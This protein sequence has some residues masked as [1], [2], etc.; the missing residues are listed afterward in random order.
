MNNGT[1]RSSAVADEI[2][3]RRDIIDPPRTAKV[4]V[5][6]KIKP[7]HL[8]RG[9][10]LYIRQSSLHQLRENQEST[11]RQYQLRERLLA[12]GW[13]RDQVVIIDEDLGVSGSGNADRD[14][15]RRLLKLVTDQ[16]LGIVL[17]LEMSRLARN[18]K[19]WHDLFEVCAVFDSL[20]ADE[21][22][23]FCPNDSNDRMVL[24]LKG[25]ISEMELHAMKVRLERGRMNK[26]ERGELFQDLPVGFVPDEGGLPEL[27]PDESARH[28]MQ[29]F[30]RLFESLGSGSKLFHHL[31][32]R[33]IKLPFRNRS[34][35]LPGHDS[36]IDWRIPSKATVLEL[37]K[38]PLYAGAYSYGRR[39]N[40]RNKHGWRSQQKFLPQEQ[41]KVLIKDRFPSY[42]SWQQ[43]E[44]NQQRLRENNTR[45]GHK[46]AVRSG[47]ALLAGIVFCG[48]CGRRITPIYRSAK[49]GSGRR[50]PD[51]VVSPVASQKD[52]GRRPL[53]NF[54]R[55]R[56]D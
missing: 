23:L 32:K 52:V 41:W 28:A 27:D 20:I 21:D 53:G 34:S 16:R 4:A 25:I 3:L 7:D 9:A 11:A 56:F 39:K 50:S 19:D 49:H 54:G 45:K 33:Q 14:G 31:A 44:A 51:R 40:Y 24:G 55:I 26:A 5:S 38:N 13:R 18:S 22:G 36:S 8:A 2:A 6:P 1:R 17:G 15:F 46:G 30:F 47:A 43:Y 42:I 37:L 12:L 29:M 35:R 10:A 48:R